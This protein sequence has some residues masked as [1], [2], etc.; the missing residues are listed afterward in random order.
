MVAEVNQKIRDLENAMDVTSTKPMAQRA[1]REKLRVMTNKYAEDAI[2][3][4]DLL[5][6]ES[7]LAQANDDYQE[8]TLA[9]L[10]AAAQLENALGEE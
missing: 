4:D 3:L 7:D 2:L 10:S 5:K 8:A 1:A 6:A 9:V